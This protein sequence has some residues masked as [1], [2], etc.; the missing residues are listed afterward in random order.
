MHVSTFLFK[1]LPYGLVE[2]KIVSHIPI[3]NMCY[4]FLLYLIHDDRS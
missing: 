4:T 2:E 3:I 1:L